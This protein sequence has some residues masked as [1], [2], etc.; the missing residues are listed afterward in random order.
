MNGAKALCVIALA[1]WSILLPT[2]GSAQFTDV[3]KGVQKAIGK[4][5]SG[6]SESSIID[7]LKEALR[8]GSGNAVGLVSQVGGYLN[9][10]AIRI[11]LPG[12]LQKAEK[13]LRATG[14]GSQLD[15]FETSM[16]RAAEKAAPEAKSI[17]WDAIKQM[18]IQ[19][20]RKILE[21]GDN[22]ATQYLRDKTYDRLRESF[23]PRVHQAMSKVG[24][25]RQ[26][27]GLE[28]RIQ[29]IPFV[30]RPETDLDGH[31]TDGALE[32]LF[33]MLAQ[34]EKKIRHDPAARVTDLLKKVFGAK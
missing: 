15:A 25:T 31:V 16:N 18:D 6:L 14:F 17:F 20:A 13:V 11:P 22:A 30:G 29:A 28:E 21:G 23:K 24:V 1:A 34:E 32:G 33:H 7:G 3:L 26:Y 27:Q 8:V 2:S 4:S 12:W 10:P 19:Q 9:N 5:G